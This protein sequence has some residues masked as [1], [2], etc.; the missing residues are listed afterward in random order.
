VLKECPKHGLTEF[1][2]RKNCNR[3]RCKHCAV[4]AVSRRRRKVKRLLVDAA[5]GRCQRCGYDKCLAAL[6][7]HHLNSEEKSFRISA[8][9][10]KSLQKLKEEIKKC[11]LL[12]ANCHAE[13]HSKE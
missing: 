12:C 11:I 5:G 2:P 3:W 8:P 13:L 4:E 10:V 1:A 7:F 6:Q 9:G